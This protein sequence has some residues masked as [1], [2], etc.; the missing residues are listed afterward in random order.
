MH[1][2]LYSVLGP[3]TGTLAWTANRNLDPGL[4]MNRPHQR[5]G[6]IGVQAAKTQKM[7]AKYFTNRRYDY[8]GKVGRHQK[9]WMPR[10]L[11]QDLG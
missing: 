9:S 7:D 10:L 11:G 3:S 5:P 2:L 4:F 1:V 8:G 6:Y